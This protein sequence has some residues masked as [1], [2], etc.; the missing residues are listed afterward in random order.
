MRSVALR[1]QKSWLL[2]LFCAVLPPLVWA[3]ECRC[4]ERPKGPGGGVQCAK[5][6]IAT[7]DPSKG[8]CNCSCDTASRGMRKEEYLSMIFSRVFDKQVTTSD[9]S[10]PRYRDLTASFLRSGTNGTYFL[11]KTVDGRQA[12]VTVS[13]PEWLVS[14]LKR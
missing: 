12:Q 4:P 1:P 8:E 2:A 7:C 14:I 10:E 9:L 6:Q 3:Q 5:D 11:T 13:L